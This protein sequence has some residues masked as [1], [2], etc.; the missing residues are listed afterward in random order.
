[1]RSG[2]TAAPCPQP[3]SRHYSR[4]GE[5]IGD[6]TK[7]R[8]APK[9]GGTMKRT[10]ATSRLSLVLPIFGCHGLLGLRRSGGFLNFFEELKRLVPN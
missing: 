3:R 9:K 2:S 5:L 4:K 6:S 10:K 8:I 1:M 7:H